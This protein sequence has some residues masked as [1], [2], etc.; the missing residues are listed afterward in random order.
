MA[1]GTLP[2]VCARHGGPATRWQRRSF[3][4]RTPWWVLVLIPI[5]LLLALVVALAV[6]GTVTANLPTCDRCD[7]ERRRFR[8][9]VVAA[10]VGDVV[11]LVAFAQLGAAGLL[12]W[13]LTTLAA[14]VWSF[15]GDRRRVSGRVSN[16]RLW[17]QLQGVHASFAAP[18]IDALRNP[19]IVGPPPPAGPPSAPDH[20]V[21]PPPSPQ[22][23]ASTPLHTILPGQ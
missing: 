11:L 9:S 4:T 15:S 18:V 19:A 1:S 16:D 13:V 22:R 23:P 7:S 12:L 17:V 14:L 3:Y 2:P 5:A 20:Y 21:A 8:L 10:W 6:R